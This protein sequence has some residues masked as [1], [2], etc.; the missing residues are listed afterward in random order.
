MGVLKENPV[1]PPQVVACVEVPWVPHE[2]KV[3]W[4][5][6]RTSTARLLVLHHFCYFMLY[7]VVHKMRNTKAGLCGSCCSSVSLLLPS[8]S[9]EPSHGLVLLGWIVPLV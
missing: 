3:C 2:R 6:R 9:Q 5:V 4:E 7:I 1:L 8:S